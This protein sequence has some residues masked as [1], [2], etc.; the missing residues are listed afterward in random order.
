M[1]KKPYLKVQ[2]LQ[3][4][5]FDW[6]WPTPLRK[7]SENN[8]ILLGPPVPYNDDDD[9]VD[10]EAGVK[11][12]FDNHAAGVWD[13]EQLAEPIYS[14]QP[15]YPKSIS[16]TNPVSTNYMYHQ[17]NCSGLMTNISTHCIPIKKHKSSVYQQ[18]PPLCLTCTRIKL[19]STT[20]PRQQHTT[21]TKPSLEMFRQ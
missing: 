4:K 12:P 17:G 3:H 7:F 13:T 5:C 1:L 8:S 16:T 10:A 9:R 18:H 6:K 2:N 11:Y 19:L 21:S 15:I 14:K 20:K